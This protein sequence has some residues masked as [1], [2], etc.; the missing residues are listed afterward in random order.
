MTSSGLA[1]YSIVLV[2][3][4]LLV[5]PAL[6]DKKDLP[7]IDLTANFSRFVDTT[8]GMDEAARVK[9]FQTQMD[10]GTR[11]IGGKTY[12]I[13]GADVI[14]QIHESRDL[15]PFLDH[16]LFHRFGYYVAL[17]VVEELGGQ[18]KLPA[19]AHMPPER[20]KT[21]LTAAMDRLINKAGGCQ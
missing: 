4:G 12:L 19:L 11:E 18:Y 20:V 13:F 2:A 17:R 1:H 5:Q 10:G 16:E 3:L 7:Y 6:G 9:A 15:T 8:A 14:T 21:T